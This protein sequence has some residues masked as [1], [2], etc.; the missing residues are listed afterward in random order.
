MPL[1][2][3]GK[4]DPGTDVDHTRKHEDDGEELKAL[5]PVVKG[6]DGEHDHGGDRGGG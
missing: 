5:Q 2:H 6:K 1:I 3:S 4:A